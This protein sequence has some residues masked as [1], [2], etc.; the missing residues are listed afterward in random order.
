MRKLLLC[1]LLVFVFSV[2]NMG[3]WSEL[4]VCFVWQVVLLQGDVDMDV[5]FG[6]VAC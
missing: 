1:L 3:R 2:V 6:D 4:S 5:M